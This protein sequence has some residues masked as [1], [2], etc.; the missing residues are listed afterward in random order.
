MSGTISGPQKL[1][2]VALRDYR[3]AVVFTIIFAILSVGGTWW[4]GVTLLE[5]DASSPSVLLPFLC[6]PLTLFAGFVSVRRFLRLRKIGTP[7]L[8]YSPARLGTS[9]SGAIVLDKRAEVLGDFTLKLGCFA[10]GPRGHDG[11]RSGLSTKPYWSGKMTVPHG[12]AQS[13]GRISFTM[14][15]PSGPQLPSKDRETYWQ[16]DVTAPMRGVNFFAR[17]SAIRFY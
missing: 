8:E 9:F 2:S 4:Y 15:L 3:H 13:S 10:Y 6:G 5:P 7:I 16:M 1:Q 11:E 17:F 12:Q 14:K